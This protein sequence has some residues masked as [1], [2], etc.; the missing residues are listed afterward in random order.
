MA[1]YSSKP[2]V[3]NKPLAELTQKFNDFTFAQNN[4]DSLPADKRQA[5]G[6]VSFSPDSINIKTPQMGE[7]KLRVV[8]RLPQAI[9]LAAEGSPVPMKLRVDFKPVTD[10]STEVT[11][12]ID[13][14]IPVIIKPM[15]GPTLQKAADKFG[16][17][18]G[19]LA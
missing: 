6:D 4:L 12:T 1:T 18:F 9:V 13:V 15:I 14:D 7:V 19:S 5:I 17:L 8:E 3:V 10:D 16:E 11:G 2:T